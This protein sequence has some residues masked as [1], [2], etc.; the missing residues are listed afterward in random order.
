MN[1]AADSRVEAA[2]TMKP[3]FVPMSAPCSQ[4]F[5]RPLLLLGALALCPAPAHAAEAKPHPGEIIYRKQCAEC[6]G[7]DG[8][9]VDGEYDEPLI[10]E[11]TLEALARKIEKTMPEDN[12]GACVGDDAKQVAA[13][14]YDAFYS[15]AAQARSKPPAK[16]L[17]RLTI[18]QY[19]NSVMDLFGHFRMGAGFDRPISN[20]QGL[21]ALYRGVE[22]PKPG[23]SNADLIPKDGIKKKRPNYKLE[24]TDPRVNF[25]FGPD[26]P[27]KE[28]ME[29]EQFDNRWEGSILAEETGIY[30]FMI[31][32]ENGARLFINDDQEALID[33]WV[34]AGPKVR[35]EK[36]SI[37]LIGGRA[38]RLILEHFKFKEQ[39]A[40]IELWW[41]P[42]HGMMEIIPP[43]VLRTDRPR[44]LTIVS[45]NF[46]ADDRSVGYE[47]GS[48]ISKDWDRATTDAALKIAEHVEKG[49]DRLIGSKEG[50]PQRHDKMRK[51]ANE[52]VE[53]AFRRPLTEEQK[54]LYV[55][56]HFKTA[57]SPEI[58]VKRI[59][60]FTLKSPHF[61]YPD[62]RLN[63]QPDA[64]DVASRL[65]LALWDSLPD[66]KL[67]QAARENKLQ[68]HDQIK[69]QAERMIADSRTKAKL[70][71][72]FHHW[73]DFEHAEGTSKDPK[74]FPGFNT[75]VLA[76][77][78]ESL[79]Q[80]IDSV[81]WSDQSDYREL[82]KADY[83]LL[84]ERLGKFYGQPVTGDEFQR[85][86]FDPKQRAGVVTHPYLL[87]SLAYSKNTSPIHRGVFLTRNIVGMSLK[88]PQM[89]VAFDESH[90]DPKLTMREKITELTRNNSCMSCHAVINPLGF[91]LENF[92]AIGRWRTKD[93]NK[94]VNPVGEF[95]DEQGVKV[96]LSGPRDIVNYVADNP[97][98]HR[99]F[100]RHLFN[101]TVKQPIPAYG[102]KVLDDLQRKFAESGCNIRKLLL[103][104]A[105]VAA[106]PSQ[107][108]AQA[109]K[110]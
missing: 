27:D 39:S 34:S 48:T 102:S 65:A 16:D 43:R 32:T 35:E 107:I 106:A 93:N 15:P 101:H 103:E 41:K 90:F 68:T 33:G 72:F 36:K 10:G 59:V 75:E 83:L 19:R 55:E 25:H 71:G 91:S 50:D 11:R 60:L 8:M 104:I 42:P 9:G 96:R 78:R 81:V 76:D 73:L 37:F 84:N 74:A 70:H 45:T 21:K 1:F 28:K 3:P 67:L 64:Y 94:P 6:H 79:L 18:P 49:L 46:P 89:A 5:S 2:V 92:D 82:L 105:L 77:L 97:S 57:K 99:A 87:A 100:I 54:Q 63:E 7:K 98:G 47:R 26:S 110:P 109:T 24:R 108:V 31:K 29:A 38:Y 51:F 95:S 20:E 17:T 88:P 53:T 14:I 85:V 62:L 52:F 69:A 12:V 30:D 22:L 4:T 44:E 23:E 80:F 66:K 56:A 58:A 40:S 86:G 61:L 13:Y